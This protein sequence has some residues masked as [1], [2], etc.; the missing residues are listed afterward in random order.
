MDR[1]LGVGRLRTAVFKLILLVG[2]GT[3]VTFFFTYDTDLF[4]ADARGLREFGV[5]S[6]R[7]VLT[8]PSG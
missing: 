4:F 6:E 1:R 3:A 8:F 5:G 2:T 7:R